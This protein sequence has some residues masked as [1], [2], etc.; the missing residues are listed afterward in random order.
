MTTF[1]DVQSELGLLATALASELK[2]HIAIKEITVPS[3]TPPKDELYF[4]KLVSWSYVALMEA[5]PVALKQLTGLLRATDSVE[6]KHFTLT[7]EV[8]CA[9]RTIQ[10]HNL[11]EGSKSGERQI[12]LSQVWITNNGG[13]P[14]CWE[15]CCSA[16]CGQ[17]LDIF[18]SL[19]QLWLKVI[20]DE[21]DKA[22]ALQRLNSAFESEWPAHTFDNAV[23]IAASSIGLLDFDVVTY[24]NN[25]LESWKKLTALFFDRESARG[26][27]ERAIAVDL[28][29]VFGEGSKSR[30]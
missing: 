24:R 11:D 27:V 8:V 10:S 18:K 7:K 1:V 15:A 30:D 4:R 5:F 3:P 25:R 14:F 26:A 29:A 21:D 9:F 16:L 2:G 17:L 28:R 13:V 23:E 20:S 22:G 19:L 6:Y 12:L